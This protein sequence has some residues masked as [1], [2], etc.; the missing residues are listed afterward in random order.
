M[1]ENTQV[2]D[3]KLMIFDLK[4][5]YKSIVLTCDE[6]YAPIMEYRD[7]LIEK[8]GF[9][10]EN[11]YGLED[12][13]YELSYQN[14]QYSLKY[15]CDEEMIIFEAIINNDE[16]LKIFRESAIHMLNEREKKTANEKT[17]K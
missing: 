8:L 2:N 14:K 7:T 11:E 13:I 16:E 4:N 10:I 12:I 1:N 3:R 5:N 9:T 17:K 15:I 6:G